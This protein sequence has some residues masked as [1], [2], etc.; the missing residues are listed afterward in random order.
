MNAVVTL[1]T[2][3]PHQLEPSQAPSGL[4]CLVIVA[5]HHGLRLSV[6][7]L[8]HDHMLSCDEVSINEVIKCATSSG[9]KAK[10]IDLNWSSLGQLKKALPVI[11]RLRNGG[12][13]VLR[14]VDDGEQGGR[15]VLQDPNAEADALL[16]VDRVR[17]EEVWT[18][19]VILVKR[20]YDISDE[21]QPFGLGLLTALMFRERWVVRDVAICAILLGF[22]SLT[23]IMFWRLMSDRVLY[24][25]AYNT[26][27][28][29]CL[30]MAI[31]IVFEAVF[32]YLRQ[33]LILHMSTRVDV[34]LSTYVFEKVLNLP[35]D[36]F[37]RTQAGK[38]FHDI[39]ELRKI[40]NFMVGQLLGT[41]LDSTTLLFFLPVM[42]FFSP[43]MT[44]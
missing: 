33:F 10:V 42:F 14:R 17:F 18:G 2:N 15:A 19:E 5:G 38:I 23:P 37:E 20:D 6:S 44:L 34:K 27:Y 43:A 26:F 3:R 21:D 32:T 1:E 9:L 11:V 28:V 12:S 7:Q 36:F 29:L 25:K 40:R 8:T 41:I 39:W 24:F 31:L 35:I 30:I 22:L 13:M 16:V 4:A